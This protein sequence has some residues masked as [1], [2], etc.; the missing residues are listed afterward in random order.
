MALL[1]LA[2]LRCREPG[3]ELTQLALEG[4]DLRRLHF[5]GRLVLHLFDPRGVEK[6][7]IGL[8]CIVVGWRDVDKHERLGIATQRVAHQDRQRVVPVGNVLGL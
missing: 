2:F 7:A 6:A 3:L 1:V 4:F 5:F 8:I